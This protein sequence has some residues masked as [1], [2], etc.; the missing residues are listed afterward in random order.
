MKKS[1]LFCPEVETT[2]TGRRRVCPW[3]PKTSKNVNPPVAGIPSV[4]PPDELSEFDFH[5]TS[6]PCHAFKEC[7]GHKFFHSCFTSE[8]ELDFLS[9]GVTDI[10]NDIIVNEICR[11]VGRASTARHK[12]NSQELPLA[13][14][15][16]DQL[17]EILYHRVQAQ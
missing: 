16:L 10:V 6:C 5:A 11:K 17:P 3:F 8:H 13:K 15:L 2:G 7:R 4:L 14:L 9:R 1:A 12:F